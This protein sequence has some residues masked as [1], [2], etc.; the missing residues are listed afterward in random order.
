[1][2]GSLGGGTGLGCWGEDGG[3]G[4]GVWGPHRAR[5]AGPRCGQN[6]SQDAGPRASAVHGTADPFGDLEELPKEN[7][8]VGRAPNL[9]Q[10]RV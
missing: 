9:L 4:H 8:G 7:G 5:G 6:C 2:E 3:G 1:M 10:S